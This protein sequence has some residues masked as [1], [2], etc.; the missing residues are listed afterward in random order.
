MLRGAIKLRAAAR[1]VQRPADERELQRDARFEHPARDLGKAVGVAQ[2]EDVDVEVAGEHESDAEGGGEASL[3]DEQ[4]E[5]AQG[6]RS[7]G[8]QHPVAGVGVV[9]GHDATVE[10]L[11]PEVIDAG[12]DVEKGLRE[13]TQ[14]GGW[15]VVWMR[16]AG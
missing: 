13:E 12:S 7:A 11:V 4:A 6:L 8:E 3:R 14:A 2:H 5:A 10:I 16:A 9:V 15:H 1:V